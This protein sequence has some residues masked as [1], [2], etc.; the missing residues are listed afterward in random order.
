LLVSQSVKGISKLF[1]DY[2]II[3]VTVYICTLNAHYASKTFL[4]FKKKN[5]FLRKGKHEC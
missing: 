2:I 4:Q 3:S 5:F 1:I